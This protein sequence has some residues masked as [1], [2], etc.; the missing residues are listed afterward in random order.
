MD[1]APLEGNRLFDKLLAGA[2][3]D[4]APGV[5]VDLLMEGAFV[6]TIL[7]RHHLLSPL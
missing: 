1:L 4:A 3:T 7:A 6:V 5:A 2:V